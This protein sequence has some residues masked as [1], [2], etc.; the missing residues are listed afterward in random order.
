MSAVGSLVLNSVKRFVNC[1]LLHTFQRVERSR[2]AIILK[3][4]KA[5]AS[6]TVPAGASNTDEN[7]TLNLPSKGLGL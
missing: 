5:Y 6:K 4:C 1:D 3:L 2:G 7:L